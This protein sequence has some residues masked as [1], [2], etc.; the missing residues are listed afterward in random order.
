MITALS[1]ET[2]KITEH[3]KKESLSIPTIAGGPHLLEWSPWRNGRGNPQG[4]LLHNKRLM[5]IAK[6]L[7]VF[8][9]YLEV[10]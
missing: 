6:V 5:P 10:L 3:L 4:F 8:I 2:K 9:R 7:D 1:Q